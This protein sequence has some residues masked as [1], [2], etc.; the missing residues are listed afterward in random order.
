MQ[1]SIENLPNSSKFIPFRLYIDIET[2]K[3]LREL[4]KK[5]QLSTE[6]HMLYKAKEHGILIDN[7]NQIITGQES[8]AESFYHI[9]K[10]LHDKLSSLKD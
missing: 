4:V 9:W 10:I 7:I 8:E 5:F 3:E 1:A 6:L 2:E